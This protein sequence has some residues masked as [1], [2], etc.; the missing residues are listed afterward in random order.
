MALHYITDSD[1]KHTA[2][3]IP[4]EE[5]HK[6]S[7]QLNDLKL[8]ELTKKKPSDFVGCIT[9]ETAQKMIDDIESSR[10]QWERNI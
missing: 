3:V 1:G 4:I 6:I 10:E 9:K 2:V 7:A 5:W 8:N